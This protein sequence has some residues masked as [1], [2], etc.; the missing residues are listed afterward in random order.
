MSGVSLCYSTVVVSDV[1]QRTNIN[2]IEDDG[3]LEKKTLL[4]EESSALTVFHSAKKEVAQGGATESLEEK[5]LRYC[6]REHQL[7][8]CNGG[9]V[10][11]FLPNCWGISIGLFSYAQRTSSA[12]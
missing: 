11:T 5:S 3:S 8:R 9:W 2:T 10:R 1:D 6:C 12:A 4:G 7:C